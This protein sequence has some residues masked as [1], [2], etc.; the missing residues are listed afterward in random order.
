MGSG[1]PDADACHNQYHI[2][3][4]SICVPDECLEYL[5]CITLT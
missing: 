4:Q 3:L 5:L 2:K 1:V